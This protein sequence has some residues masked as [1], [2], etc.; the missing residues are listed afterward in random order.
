MSAI[1]PAVA[2]TAACALMLTGLSLSVSLRRR[3]LGASFGDAGDETLR[4][5]I[6][7]HGNFIEYAPMAAL[8]VWALAAASIDTALVWTFALAF[9]GARLLHAAG[10]LATRSPTPRAIAM[11]LQHLA[12]VAAAILLAGVL[13]GLA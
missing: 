13:L 5:R 4:R 12:F 2:L 3:A 8:T 11:V 7:A 1:A 6:R 10:M 9:L